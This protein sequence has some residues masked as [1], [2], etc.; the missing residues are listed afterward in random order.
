[1]RSGNTYTVNG[2]AE[3]IEK[4]VANIKSDDLEIMFRMDS[5]YFDEEIIETIEK[6]G[7]K[8]LI[9]GKA[10]PTLLAYLQMF[11]IY[12]LR[13]RKVEKQL[14]FLP[15]W[16]TGIQTEDSLFQGS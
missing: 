9:K 1:M 14:N 16:T 8:Y 5:G 2:A 4:I 7:C 6:L 11:I 15:N 12:M 13:A 3:M 10:Y